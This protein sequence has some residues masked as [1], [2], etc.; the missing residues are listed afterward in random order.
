MIYSYMRYGRNQSRF[1]LYSYKSSGF[2]IL[3][4]VPNPNRN[5]RELARPALEERKHLEFLR[6]RQ[7]LGFHPDN[8][9]H[10]NKKII[11]IFFARNIGYV[12]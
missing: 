6:K 2:P 5:L 8:T 7:D 11:I 4:K 3:L 1:P 9:P 12:A 10:L